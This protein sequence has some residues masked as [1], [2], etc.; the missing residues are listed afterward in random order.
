MNRLHPDHGNEVAEDPAPGWAVK[1]AAPDGYTVLVTSL[2]PLVIAPLTSSEG[3]SRVTVHSA[4]A[5]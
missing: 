3:N 5:A 2:G 1:R 4:P